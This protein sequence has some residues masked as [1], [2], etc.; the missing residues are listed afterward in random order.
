MA[1]S[2]QYVMGGGPS[3]QQRLL[4]Q[5]QEF[6]R[7]AR[8]LIDQIG[9]QPGWRVA[10]LGCGPIGILDRLAER[11]GIAGQVIGVERESRFVSMARSV[12]AERTLRNVD[13]VQADATRT[14]LPAAYFDLV[15]ERLTL[16]QQA[17][18]RPLLSE[19]VR[20]T[21]PGG[22]VAVQDID[23]GAWFCDPP[24]IAWSKL[25][26]ALLT[27]CRE[28]GMDV[29]LGRRLLGL[30]RAAGL[31]DVRVEV[32]IWRPQPGEYLRTLVLS[33]ASGV[34][35]GIFQRGLLTEAEFAAESDALQKHVDRPDTL[36]IGPL[37][38]QVWGRKPAT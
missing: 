38:F 27:V 16:L 7:D 30:L 36:V 2:M 19:M 25:S 21:R 3:E 35:A 15:H 28:H 33:L 12:I 4:A 1:A 34:Q 20:L 32:S 14:G 18:P 29:H 9:V 17:D 37:L 22:V 31:D 8:W 5:A 11:V 6:D 23:T 13:I 26:D 24:S 10:D